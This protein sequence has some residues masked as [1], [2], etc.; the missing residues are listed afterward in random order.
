MLDFLT[1]TGVDSETPMKD[2]LSIAQSYGKSH[3]EFGVLVGSHTGE[4]NHGTTWM[5]NPF[6]RQA[7]WRGRVGRARELPAP[8][9]GPIGCSIT[10]E[11]VQ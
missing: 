4:S 7:Y 6:R 1:F 3:V 11:R 8:S 5:M 9:A 2:L 10:P